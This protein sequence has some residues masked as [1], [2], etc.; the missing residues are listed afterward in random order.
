MFAPESIIAAF[1]AN[2]ATGVEVANT[3]PLPTTLRGTTVRV[4]DSAGTERLAPLFFV[5]PGQINYLLPAN[6]ATGQATVT[7]TSG[8]GDIS[9]GTLLVSAISPA[10][11]SANANGSG[12][13]AA[14]VLRV[15]ANGQQVFEAAMRFDQASNRF[16]PE[17]INLGPESEQVYLV[18]YGSG[19]RGY[20]NAVTATLGGAPINVIF[21]G[22][23]GG[24][25]G[26]D[27]LN[28]GPVPRSLAGRG[29]VDLVVTVDGKQANTV[30]FSIR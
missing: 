7:A 11:F 24:F 12:V 29:V 1:G 27:Q 17:P 14:N 13:A 30:Q 5:S 9:F 18:V 20:S 26:L 19:L 15:L 8:N 10:L 23:Q 22:P 21:V 4:R 2:L 28:L 3:T 6:T 25:A 16:V